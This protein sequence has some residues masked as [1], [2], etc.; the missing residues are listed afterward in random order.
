MDSMNLKL[1]DIDKIHVDE[2]F[3][4]RGHFNKIDVSDLAADIEKQ[5]E[6]NPET[7][8]L[9][10]PVTVRVYGPEEA[11]ATGFPYGLV[12][13]FRRL[14][15]F[16]VL[17]RKQI[18]AF[19]KENMSAVQ[20]AIVNLSE[21]IH[22][23]DLNVLQEAHALKKLKDKGIGREIIAKEIG[24][25]PGWVQVRF[26]LLDLPEEIQLEA[27]AG[28]ITQFHIKQLYS[29][30]DKQKQ[31]EAVRKIKTAKANNERAA[32]VVIQK[33]TS[34]ANTKRVR[35]RPDIFHM[36]DY[37]SSTIGR[38]LH[39]RFGA[40]SAGEITDYEFLQA[41]KEYADEHGIDYTIPTGGTIPA[42]FVSP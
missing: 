33:P 9:L 39:T 10:N 35:S 30:K 31:F 15:A 42:E 2:E 29:I 26:N 23:Q 40:W 25:S 17:G 22:R 5:T 8:G 18:P 14:F 36:M 38:G 32:D 11:K 12:A 19:H 20:A 24:K 6:V 7:L 21:N 41:M 37:M 13:G 1:T 28:T 27:A 3:N 16:K 34:S 4:S